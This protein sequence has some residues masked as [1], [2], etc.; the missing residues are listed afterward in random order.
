MRVPKTE[1]FNRATY[2]EAIHI[3]ESVA[4]VPVL[5]QGLILSKDDI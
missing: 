4:F 5:S 3:S 1:L 2:V